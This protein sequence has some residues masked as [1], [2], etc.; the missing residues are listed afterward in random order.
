M[1]TSVWTPT[2]LFP[3]TLATFFPIQWKE[4]TVESNGI[5]LS[6]YFPPVSCLFWECSA[7]PVRAARLFEQLFVN[8]ST[9]VL[10][11]VA[12]SVLHKSF[13]LFGFSVQDATGMTTFW[14]PQLESINE[15]VEMIFV[16][17]ILVQKIATLEITTQGKPI[18][19]IFRYFLIFRSPSQP[20]RTISRLMT[21][22]LESLLM[23]QT[24]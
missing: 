17:P 13:L 24:V 5:I 22:T 1:F 14:L 8:H 2:H 4:M 16:D 12:A 3:K 18:T 10:P 7:C 19:H 20:L 9:I 23:L 11:L 21:P 6:R 15:N